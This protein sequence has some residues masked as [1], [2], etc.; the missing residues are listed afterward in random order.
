MIATRKSQRYGQSKN[1]STKNDAP[2]V[3][4]SVPKRQESDDKQATKSAIVDDK[5]APLKEI[6]DP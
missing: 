6:P 3:S 1:K 5:S 4:Q 2:T